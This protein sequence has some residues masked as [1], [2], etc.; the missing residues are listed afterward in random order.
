MSYILYV[1]LCSI[2]YAVPLAKKSNDGPNGPNMNKRRVRRPCHG[3]GGGAQHMFDTP[4]TSHQT[5]THMSVFAKSFVIWSGREIHRSSKSHRWGAVFCTSFRGA[6]ERIAALSSF[7][8][9]GW[10]GPRKWAP[11]SIPTNGDLCEKRVRQT[12]LIRKG[13]CPAT[14]TPSAVRSLHRRDKSICKFR[15]TTWCCKVWVEELLWYFVRMSISC[16]DYDVP[17][18]KEKTDE[19]ISWW[20]IP[21]LR[22]CVP[23]S[24]YQVWSFLL[25]DQK[26]TSLADRTILRQITL[27]KLLGLV[28]VFSF[29]LASPFDC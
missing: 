12:K 11:C 2:F 4:P 13:F 16:C 28:E 3:V 23:S 21:C 15:S 5:G 24:F 20:W 10:R 25:L 17:L 19:N 14:V 7:Y 29:L 9:N 18:N 1:G 8:R 26:V 27:I 6:N 22:Y